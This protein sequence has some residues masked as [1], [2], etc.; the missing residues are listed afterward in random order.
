MR[1]LFH[2]HSRRAFTTTLI[3][4][5]F[6]LTREHTVVLV[7]EQLSDDTVALLQQR[8]RFPGLE[9]I[10]TTDPLEFRPW[11]LL[12][13]NRKIHRFIR[14]LILTHRPDV[15][16]SENDMMSLF[17]LY[18]FRVAKLRRIP[19]ATFQ[20]MTEFRE[21][22]N[23]TYNQLM[24]L[25]PR[26]E[27]ARG[28]IRAARLVRIWLRKQLGHLLVHAILPLLAGLGIL[29]GKS[30][31]MKWRG[32]SGMRDGDLNLVLTPE[33]F[34]EYARRGVPVEK[35]GLLRHPLQR[36]VP[37]DLF[38]GPTEPEPGA[39]SP[40]KPTFLV[41]MGFVTLGFERDTLW[42]IPEEKRRA[43]FIGVLAL[44]RQMLPDW[45]IRLKPHPNWKTRE[46]VL[47]FL[48]SLDPTV[49]LIEP[50]ERVESQLA[51]A[52]AVLDLPP[53]AS[54]TLFIA[55]LAYP[56]KPVIAADVLDEFY[57]DNYHYTDG[58]DYCR[59]MSELEELLRRI[60]THSFAKQA[61]S[62]RPAIPYQ[63][64]T[65]AGEVITR[66]LGSRPS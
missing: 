58:I 18:L 46:K 52:S 16:V 66:L 55:A 28:V 50:G 7:S 32:A 26:G 24:H 59:G 21:E 64:F 4:N 30:S 25:H 40:A 9:C 6:E 10:I 42:P 37:P 17:D 35:L 23:Q 49:E 44:I 36:G 56:N 65:S 54:T 15:I 62:T 48:G 38:L 5:L 47:A 51:G 14:N 27:P 34:A 19:T 53:A 61:K 3:G 11:A 31:Y 12:K 60:N 1:I 43:A 13:A 8:S 45:R 57:G 29:W 33:T 41:L 22:D 20:S 2:T 39:G 63:E